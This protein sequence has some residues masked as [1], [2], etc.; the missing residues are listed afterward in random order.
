MAELKTKP[1]QASVDAFLNS[2]KDDQV[3]SDCRVLI[4][5]MQQATKAKPQMW[6]TT[7]S[8]HALANMRAA[9]HVFTSSAC[10]TSICQ[11]LENLFRP[12][13]S[14][15]ENRNL[16]NKLLGS[17]RRFGMRHD[18]LDRLPARTG[19]FV[20]ESGY[21]TDLWLTLDALFVNPSGLAPLVA[22]LGKRIRPHNPAAVCGPLEGGA[23]LAQALATAL[24][25]DFYF[26]RPGD[27]D[28]RK[29]FGTQYQLPLGFQERARGQ[30]IAVVDDVIGVGSSVR[31]TTQAVTA[32]GGST[33]VVGTL[34]LLGTSAL[35]HFAALA[36]PI[37]FLAQR[38]FALWDP[39]TCPL[40]AR[41]V[42]LQQS[43]STS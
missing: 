36:I 33:V 11:R 13:S 39:A 1:T 19:H 23:F 8:G 37:E 3:R 32:A 35:D 4:D 16:P 31:A 9:S 22:E 5:I 24:D 21:H 10:R 42:P 2:I 18:F 25:V 17:A 40:C 27:V 29:L 41:N 34:L 7:S 12:L 6:S 14:T 30:R 28:V 43:H 20:L 15:C 38:A 26:S